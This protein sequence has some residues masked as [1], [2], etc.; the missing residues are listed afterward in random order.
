MTNNVHHGLVPIVPLL[1]TLFFHLKVVYIL[2]QHD[3]TKKP[4]CPY[5][6]ASLYVVRLADI[7]VTLKGQSAHKA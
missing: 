2:K 7:K 1:F 4:C 3:N 5:Y 6:K